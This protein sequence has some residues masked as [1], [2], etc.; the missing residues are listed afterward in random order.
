MKKYAPL[1]FL[2]LGALFACC[3]AAHPPALAV[4]MDKSS[5]T[6]ECAVLVRGGTIQIS[7]YQPDSLDKYCESFPS[8]GKAIFAF[9]FSTPDMR[10]LPVELRIIKDPMIPLSSDTDLGPLTVAY[11][12]QAVHKSGTFTFEH[13]FP[14]SGHFIALLTVTEPGGEKKTAEFKFSVGKTFLGLYP[15][16]L[17]GILIAG[18]LFFYWRHFSRRPKPS[19]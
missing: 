15:L 5:Q 11:M 13:D 19:S 8:T 3:I 14:E 7:G 6:K 2:F 10:D 9:D 17:G 4:S 1:P 18:V 12:A 16:I